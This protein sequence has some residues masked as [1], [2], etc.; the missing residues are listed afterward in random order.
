[1]RC[2][3]A[4]VRRPP[5]HPLGRRRTNQSR[6]PGAALFS[7]SHHGPRG[8]GCDYRSGSEGCE[9]PSVSFRNPDNGVDREGPT[10]SPLTLL[11]LGALLSAVAGVAYWLGEATAP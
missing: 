3:T 6:Q 8:Q 1:M 5:C 4:V 10:L 9:C 11:L 7:P 2:P